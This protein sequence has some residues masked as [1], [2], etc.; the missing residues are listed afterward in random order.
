M[1]TIYVLIREDQNQHGFVDTGIVGTFRERSQA[2]A[3]L[4]REEGA[5]RRQGALVRGD[6]VGE[7]EGEWE[8]CWTIEEH[9]LVDQDSSVA[10]V[11]P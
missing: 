7:M 1:V 11:A 9:A 3:V 6:D 2:R 10:S 8:V 4:E 5:A